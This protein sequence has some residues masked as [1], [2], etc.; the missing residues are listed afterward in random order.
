MPKRVARSNIGYRQV[1]NQM[2]IKL[3]LAALEKSKLILSEFKVLRN[4]LPP[5]L[6]GRS[7]LN[8]K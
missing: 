5:A 4:L 3:L 6:R 7:R 2:G 8:L 1:R